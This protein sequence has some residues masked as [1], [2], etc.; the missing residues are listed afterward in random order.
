MILHQQ[1]PKREKQFTEAEQRQLLT[2]HNKG[3]SN[4]EVGKIMGIDPKRLKQKANAMG[5]S[6]RKAK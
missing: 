4:I 5:V 3:L 1:R 2:Y 6:L